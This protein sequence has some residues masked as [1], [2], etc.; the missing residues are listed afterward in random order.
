MIDKTEGC[1]ARSCGNPDRC[2][3]EQSSQGVAANIDAVIEGGP[4][5]LVGYGLPTSSLQFHLGCPGRVVDVEADEKV[6]IDRYLM[7]DLAVDG[8]GNWSVGWAPC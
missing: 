2:S 3:Q 8:L 5:Y 6:F 7:G 1:Q 4:G